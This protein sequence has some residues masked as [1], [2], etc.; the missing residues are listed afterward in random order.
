[1]SA[2]TDPPDFFKEIRALASPPA[3]AHLREADPD[4]GKLQD[5]FE[6][7]ITHLLT[8]I[9]QPNREAVEKFLDA[10]RRT[11]LHVSAGRGDEAMDVPVYCLGQLTA[12][13]G[14]A[15]AVARQ[16]VPKGAV[17]VL[18][19]S[20]VAEQV[21]DCLIEFGSMRLVELARKLDKASQNL[22][23][24]ID[25]MEAA[26]LARREAAGRHVR[27]WATPLTR[28]AVRLLQ[29]DSVPDMEPSMP[30]R[31]AQERERG[32]EYP[33]VAAFVIARCRKVMAAGDDDRKLAEAQRAAREF[34]AKFPAEAEDEEL[35]HLTQKLTSASSYLL[36]ES[37]TRLLGSEPVIYLP[38]VLSWDTRGS[39]VLNVMDLLPMLQTCNLGGVT[40]E[41][42]GSMVL[43][44]AALRAAAT[45]GASP[46]AWIV[47]Q[48]PRVNRRWWPEAA[49]TKMTRQARSVLDDPSSPAIS[50]IWAESVAAVQAG[51]RVAEP[52]GE[53]A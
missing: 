53:G 16:K 40:P 45:S 47:L 29:T 26:G 9:H 48:N 51:R 49:R 36:E 14:V 39:L 43:T 5:E 15:E 2:T 31:V 27:L 13:T 46:A 18:T 33:D 28:A 19:R 7:M 44:E 41:K 4:F 1:M 12:I 34:K 20:P 24:V 11:A 38:G 25:R 30:S 10:G 21:A 35:Y 17:D 42:L 6:V 37:D 32:G 52:S 22:V 3:P 23:P 8:L 50:R